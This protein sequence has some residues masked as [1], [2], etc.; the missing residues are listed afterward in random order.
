MTILLPGRV[1]LIGRLWRLWVV[2][3]FFAVL[4]IPIS[5]LTHF[6]QSKYSPEL[7]G[8]LALVLGLAL[9]A[10]YFIVL[11][12]VAARMLFY[13]RDGFITGILAAFPFLLLIAAA[14]LYLN[15]VPHNTIGYALIM[16]PVMFPFS[17]WIEQVYPALPYH[18]LNLS[19]PLVIFTAACIGSLLGEKK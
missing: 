11:T 10:A 1:S 15:R 14:L 5:A 12:R 18:V 17:A 13:F 16:L 7:A 6:L 8:T 9:F 4:S 2:H 3:L 19:V